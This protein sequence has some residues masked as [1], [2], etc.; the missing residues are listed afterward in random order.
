MS[1]PATL[2]MD[3]L[4]IGHGATSVPFASHQSVRHLP[5][6]PTKFDRRSF[7]RTKSFPRDPII[8]R[9]GLEGCRSPTAQAVPAIRA[10]LNTAADAM[11]VPWCDTTLRA[12]THQIHFIHHN[13]ISF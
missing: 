6:K 13:L 7:R 9:D 2:F 5:T 8:E 1:R 4:Q 11:P 10:E 12:I 3:T